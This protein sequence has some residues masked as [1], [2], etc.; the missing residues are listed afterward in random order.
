M[1]SRNVSGS[2]RHKVPFLRFDLSSLSAPTDNTTLQLWVPSS[3]LD[4]ESFSID[5]FGVND[6]VSGEDKWNAA[7]LSYNT[8]PGLTTGNADVDRDH[9]A[10]EVSY[11]GSITYPGSNYTG[12]IEL[13]SQELGDFIAADTNGAATIFLEAQVADVGRDFAIHIRTAE[14]VG[15]Q[16]DD[17]APTLVFSDGVPQSVVTSTDTGSSII[18]DNGIVQAVFTKDD[19]VCTD[20]RLEGG[21]NLLANGGRLYLDSNSGGSYYGYNGTYELLESTDQ[22]AHIRFTGRMG[23]F[24]AT[25]NYV[26]QAGESGF[27]AYVELDHGAGDAAAYL[28]Q[29]R[30]VMRCDPTIFDRAF[31]SETKT[32][33]MIDPALI[34][35]TPQ[36]IDATHKL[37]ASSSYTETTGL[38]EDGFPTYTKYDWADYIENHKAHGLSSQTAGLWMLTGSE[39]YMNG[40][41]GKAELMVHSTSQDTAGC[42]RTL[43]K[44]LRPS[45]TR[46]PSW[47]G[48]CRRPTSRSDAWPSGRGKA[49]RAW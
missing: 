44:A 3:G 7:S 2:V 24:T 31:S 9:V 39:E 22:K 1:R 33:Q 35:S 11:L 45:E 19:G 28:E 15:T 27:H 21:S 16:A 10:N 48:R 12:A 8:A 41:S 32:G 4:S 29:F 26:L 6:G 20:L 37:P 49:R 47:C 23:E 30:M 17:F 36:V 34:A 38:T 46:C 18:L 40:G 13:S 25:L 14:G 43:A 42:R 5:V